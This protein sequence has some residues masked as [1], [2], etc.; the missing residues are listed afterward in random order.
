MIVVLICV[1]LM[2]PISAMA[3][4]N[5]TGESLG[6]ESE[7]LTYCDEIQRKIEDYF[8]I[9]AMILLGGGESIQN[10]DFD[11]N[12]C[13]S[14]VMRKEQGRSG[15]KDLFA[16]EHKVYI[17]GVEV[18]P[19][20]L[21]ARSSKTLGEKH[22]DLQ[23]YEWNWVAYNDGHDGPID[24]MGYATIH[25]IVV[26]RNCAGEYSIIDDRYDES[27]LLTS[28]TEEDG[29]SQYENN[30]YTSYYE[31][32]SRRS[33]KSSNYNVNNAIEYA[34]NF[35]A[36]A[37]ASDASV[38]PGN[39]NTSVYGYYTGGDCAN[40]VSQ[41]MRSGGMTFNYGSGQDYTDW[42]ATQWWYDTTVGNLI[43]NYSACP[44]SWR[45]VPKFI[46]YWTNQGYQNVS[47]TNSNVYPGNP[48]LS[49][50]A[51]ATI[52]VGYNHQGIPIVNAHTRD[53][54]HIP[55][56]MIGSNRTTILING[57]NVLSNTPANATVITPTSSNQTLLR[58]LSANCNNFFK[59]T[60]TST[61][62]Y[63]FESTYYNNTPFDTRAY[64]YKETS[65]SNGETL[66]MYEIARD[67]DGGT[68]YN[69]KIRLSLSPGTYYLRVRACNPA[70]TG[71]YYLNYKKG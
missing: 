47:A 18:Y 46:D 57:W 53:V 42:T 15:M 11:S 68:N 45:Y 32:P 3:D 23:V 39:Y 64:L 26:E 59:L 65:T 35:V 16:R 58:Y 4:S 62:Y 40:F 56:T 10:R 24:Y 9:R 27:D 49:G 30:Y 43:D 17:Q 71:N 37:Y 54:Y 52:C 50:T 34:D 22:Y 41:C 38:H 55:Y 70:I 1:L 31:S 2:C 51:H 29:S 60:V 5:E 69:F 36:H 67:D 63:T 48:V 61:S 6:I 66:Y 19:T 8:K 7:K 28:G 44:P 20:I 12:L 13:S 14:E 25:D 33:D 21:S